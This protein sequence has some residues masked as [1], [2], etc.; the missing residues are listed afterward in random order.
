MPHNTNKYKTLEN[1]QVKTKNT[2]K[3]GDPL[4]WL[5]VKQAMVNLIRGLSTG[6]SLLP[7]LAPAKA[8]ATTRRLSGCTTPG[9]APCRV[10]TLLA[11]G[12]ST[13]TSNTG[14]MGRKQHIMDLLFTTRKP[15]KPHRHQGV[16]F[17]SKLLIP[18]AW[19]NCSFR[20]PNL[21]IH[22]YCLW[23]H[24]HACLLICGKPVWF[25]TVL[26]ETGLETSV[27]FLKLR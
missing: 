6:L 8:G 9:C 25:D 12:K 19:M 20:P 5:S 4:R 26:S 1:Q 15:K 10:C 24:H 22:M 27:V 23:C 7:G 18:F 14:R 2:S 3:R 16:C 11:S 13:M 17:H 21:S